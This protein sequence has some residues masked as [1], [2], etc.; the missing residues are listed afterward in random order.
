MALGFCTRVATALTWLGVCS[1]HVRQPYVL[2]GGDHLTRNLLLLALLTPRLADVC[3]VD[4]V[5]AHGCAPTPVPPQQQP[6]PPRVCPDEGAQEAEAAEEGRAAAERGHLV[7]SAATAGFLLQPIS[8]YLQTACKKSAGEEWHWDTLTAVHF[9]L[10]VHKWQLGPLPAALLHL[11][12]HLGDAEPLRALLRA[13]GGAGGALPDAGLALTQI[14]TA[15]TLAAEYGAPL[16]LACPWR[17]PRALGIAALLG[18][19]VSKLPPCRIAT[20]RPFC[21]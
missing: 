9:S 5:L 18:L 19:Q 12:A 4:A 13:L 14:L 2:N 3:S 16:L 15:F 8:C 21:A 20:A 11:Q 1:L 17:L 6:S 10:S 7:V